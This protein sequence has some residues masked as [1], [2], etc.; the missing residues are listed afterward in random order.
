MT[1]SRRDGK[2]FDR[3]GPGGQHCGHITSGPVSGSGNLGRTPKVP[4]R[5]EVGMRPPSIG[6]GNHPSEE[7][8]DRTQ[9]E[10]AAERR[11]AARLRGLAPGRPGRRPPVRRAGQR[12]ALRARGRRRPPRRRRSPT[13]RGASS[14]PTASN[15]VLVC[16][17]LTGDSHA[18]GPQRRRPPRPRAGGTALIGPGRAARHRPLVR[19]VRQRARRLPGHAPGRRRSTRPPAGRT[20][21]ASRW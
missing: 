1:S 13:R 14:T 2:V 11:P 7:H 16:H 3:R 4:T 8:D 15:A 9:P 5:R 20:A 19:G 18:A 6:G 10:G 12:P 17:A 21:R